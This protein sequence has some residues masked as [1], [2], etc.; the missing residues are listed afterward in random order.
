MGKISLYRQ[1]QSRTSSVKPKKSMKHI[2]SNAALTSSSFEGFDCAYPTR[3]KIKQTK[4]T[5][6]V[7]IPMASGLNVFKKQQLQIKRK[8]SAWFQAKSTRTQ[9]TYISLSPNG[10][11]RF[12]K[13]FP[14]IPFRR[15]YCAMF[16]IRRFVRIYPNTATVK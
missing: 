1:G 2:D 6:P 3:Q 9:N 13:S 14:L 4:K 10:V 15:V 16:G 8:R 12:P 11:P 7:T 5:V